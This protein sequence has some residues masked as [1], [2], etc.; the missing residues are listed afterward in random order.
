MAMGF[1][2]GILRV[3]E[4]GEMTLFSRKN[5]KAKPSNWPILLVRDQFNQFSID[6]NAHRFSSPN[7]TK[8]LTSLPI[9]LSKQLVRSDS[10]NHGRTGIAFP[11]TNCT[12][13]EAGGGNFMAL[14]VSLSSCE[15]E[16]SI[17]LLVEALKPIYWSIWE[18]HN[19]VADE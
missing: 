13:F 10:M 3:F 5:S 11:I 6:L 1:Q 18:A 4:R 16:I 2:K 12:S 8:D 15:V 7:R 17:F 19:L 14:M 9:F